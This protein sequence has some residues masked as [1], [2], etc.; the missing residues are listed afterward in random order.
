MDRKPFIPPPPSGLKKE[1]IEEQNVDNLENQQFSTEQ[2][3]LS[4]QS[5]SN[6]QTSS[7]NPPFSGTAEENKPQQ[8]AKTKNPK[9][10]QKKNN[11]NLINWIGFTLSIAALI[12][13]VYLLFI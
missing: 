13:F 8:N 1:N 3:V 9:T 12:L 11:T 5:F 6:E 10:K 2:T 4:E 7:T